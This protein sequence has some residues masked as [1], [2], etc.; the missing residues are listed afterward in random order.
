MQTFD[1][2]KFGAPVSYDPGVAT[3]AHCAYCQSQLALPDELR[4]QPARVISQIDM[5][6]WLQEWSSTTRTNSSLSR[7]TR[8]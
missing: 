8:W 3:T 2:P 6:A 1:C 7:A 5:T 4:G